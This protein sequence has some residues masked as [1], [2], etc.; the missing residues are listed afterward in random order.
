MWRKREVLAAALTIA[1]QHGYRPEQT[2]AAKP[3]T[4]GAGGPTAWVVDYGDHDELAA[5][6]MRLLR[7]GTNDGAAYNF[8][9]AQV[10]ALANIDPARKARRLKEIS[11]MVDSAREKIEAEKEAAA[12]AAAVPA[13]PPAVLPAS[14]RAKALAAA[15]ET[16][17]YWL[18]KFYDLDVLNAT[19]AAGAAEQL[20]GDPLWLLVVSGP[21]NA[22]TET[23]QSLSGAGAHVT[24]TIS[25]EGALLSATPQKQKGKGAT[26][27]LLRKIGA[28]GIL[29]IKDFTSTLPADRNV[30]GQVLAAIREVYD[31][32]WERNVGADG[33]LTLT[34]TG[35]IVVVGAVTT[36][37]D[38]A[39]G[40]ISQM[41]DRFVLIRSD[42]TVAR[43]A[44]ATKAIGNVG[45]EKTMREAL[46]KAAGEIVG[47]A[48]R[49]VR[50][51]NDEE[52]AELVKAANIVTSARTAVE[53]DYRGDVIDA[54]APE[55]PTRFAK[56][57]AQVGGLAI[58]M[59]DKDAMALAIRCARD[60][61]PPLRRE[62]LLYVAKQPGVKPP[63]VHRGVGRPRNTVRREL[64]ALYIL[65]LLKC[66]EE[67][68]E[69]SRGRMST[70][71]RYSIDNNFDH[72]TPAAM[73]AACAQP[74][75]PIPTPAPPPTSAPNPLQQ[76]APKAKQATNMT[77][78]EKLD[79][80]RGGGVRFDLWQDASGL[81]P[82]YQLVDGAGLNMMLDMVKDHYDEILAQLRKEAGL[83]PN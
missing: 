77:P 63:E 81:T 66:A 47:G 24:S 13:P 72:A 52:T 21:A 56:Q 28:R 42:S 10:E 73:N 14:G 33:G 34:W 69:D 44:A 15:H 31:G 6:S 30:R 8:L 5:H 78:R 64:E 80:M 3:K 62:I 29:V 46:A 22:K 12:A 82:D 48:D 59:S 39:H 79:A 27:G 16:Y 49:N 41:G 2:K 50:D 51:L 4:N 65:R 76:Q 40:V 11:G 57:L 61:I 60:S 19:L 35:R 37:W 17:A 32:K 23:V 68:K 25:S 45:R 18:G 55:M 26:G 54:H 36:A 58:G 67:D 7:S 53:R 1:E 20:E 70:I 74:G 75:A 38:A 83:A 43:I 71:L 9:K